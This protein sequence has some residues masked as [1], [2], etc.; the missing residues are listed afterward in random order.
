[1][2]NMVSMAGLNF[3]VQAIRDQISSALQVL[4]HVGRL[5][6]GPRKI[7]QVCEITGMEGDTICLHELF[8]FNQTGINEYGNAYGE[9]EACGVRP[10]LLSRLKAHGV[11]LPTDLFHRRILSKSEEGSRP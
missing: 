2:E 6:G 7:V 11:E 10:A 8:R 9:F 4:I 1:V 5:P 3:P